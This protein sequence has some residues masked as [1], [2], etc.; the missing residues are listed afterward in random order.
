MRPNERRERIVEL[1]RERERVT[2]EELAQS[3]GTSQE[4]IR[5]DLVELSD[6]GLLVKY[7]GGASVLPHNDFENAFQTRMHEHADEKRAIAECAA[8]L[9][10]TTD[11]VF[12][13]TGTTTLFFANAL[14]KL[15]RLTVITNSTQIAKVMGRAEHKT[16]LIGGEYIAESQQNT[17]ALALEQIRRFHAEHAVITIGALS[18]DGALD[19]LMEEAEIARAMVAQART[20]TVVVDSSKFKRSGLFELFPLTRINRLVTDRLPD[21]ELLHALNAANVEIHVAQPIA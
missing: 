1:V 12:M 9:F 20:V 18:T 2:V 8:K 14:S 13:D 5:R 15:S 4:T 10:R 11:T 17:G 21:D 6:K 16:F 19:Y 7:H 3:V